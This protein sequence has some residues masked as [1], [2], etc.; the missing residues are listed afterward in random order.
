MIFFSANSA[1]V[2]QLGKA[3]SDA[4]VPCE[5]RK[6][7]IVEGAPVKLPEAELWVQNNNDSHRAFL[8][9]VERNVGFARREI[10]GFA[11]DSLPEGL[12]A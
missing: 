1:E 6:E 11:F 8:L 7:V 5:V 9:C 12:A 10:R 4:G 2:Q 3:L